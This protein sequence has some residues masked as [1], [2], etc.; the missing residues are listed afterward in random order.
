MK[1][2]NQPAQ[3]I[4]LVSNRLPFTVAQHGDDIE[5]H[6]SAGGVASGL[7]A[8]LT[9]ANPS[10]RENAEYL[11]IGWSGAAVPD[12]LRQASSAR[13]GAVAL[14]RV[15]GVLIRSG[16]QRFLLGLL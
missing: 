11:W 13:Q 7:H 4:V 10:A 8:L 14:S 16:D 1:A 6:P 2:E 3:R 9:S 5:F 12:E 15:A